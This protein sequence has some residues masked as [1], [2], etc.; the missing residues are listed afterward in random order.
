MPAL[1]GS[2][3]GRAAPGRPY[4]TP[5]H[6]PVPLTHPML[7]FVTPLC[8]DLFTCLLLSLAVSNVRAELD[9]E[10]PVPNPVFGSQ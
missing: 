8:C 9:L 7:A 10:L 1:P 6:G 3:G 5:L 4:L 2:D